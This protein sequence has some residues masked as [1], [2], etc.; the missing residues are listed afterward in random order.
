[1]P[2]AYLRTAEILALR[3]E[4]L[5][6]VAAHNGDLAAARRCG[7][8]TGFVRRPNEHGRDQSTDLRP[9]QDWDLVAEDFND[10]ATKL[11]T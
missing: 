2:E 11:G 1:M 10:L 3:P 8:K 9:E 5:C 7:L 6:L 4:E